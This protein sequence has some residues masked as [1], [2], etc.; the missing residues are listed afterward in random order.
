MVKK[1]QKRSKNH[2]KTAKIR[3]KGL[4]SPTHRKKNRKKTN[5]LKN[6][7]KYLEKT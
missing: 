7:N 2:E 3:K 5:I 6:K 1:T 4:T